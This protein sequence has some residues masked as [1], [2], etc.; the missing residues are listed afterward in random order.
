MLH[1][2][3]NPSADMWPPRRLHNVLL[4]MFDDLR[5]QLRSSRRVQGDE[6]TSFMRT[7]HLDALAS[8]SLSLSRAHVQVALCGPS[9]SSILVG[10]MPETVC[11]FPL[12]GSGVA[13]NWRVGGAAGGAGCEECRSLPE[14][15]RESGYT[16][17]GWGKVF[18]QSHVHG[19]DEADNPRSWD[20]WHNFGHPS[21]RS[22][23]FASGYFHNLH[24]TSMAVPAEVAKKK[25]LP[26]ELTVEGALPD[27]AR[28]ERA[29]QAPGGKPW[30]FAHGL[31]K[32]HEPFVAPARF[33]D[34]YPADSLPL[35]PSRECPPADSVPKHA[36][37]ASWPTEKRDV[38]DWKQCSIAGNG[39]PSDGKVDACN[40]AHC[41]PGTSSEVWMRQA[42]FA[43]VSHVD[44]L[45]GRLLDHV[46]GLGAWNHTVVVAFGDHGLKLGDHGLWGK[47]DNFHIDTHIPLLLRVPGLTA[48]SVESDA[49]VEA[50]DIFP[51]VVEAAGLPPVP[52]ISSTLE[53][54]PPDTG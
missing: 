9:R 27:L 12:D 32:P 51:S 16:A 49:M 52:R 29:R 19:S 48:P 38:K 53:S 42:Y 44:E 39:H 37:T 18:H 26:D 41:I 40:L 23:L 7:P 1:A 31:I 17:E 5:V 15:F 33:F 3:S 47:W 2:A 6:S 14:H 21:Y 35:S 11:S 4:L 24:L 28:L 36:F 43:C 50:V 25:P 22:L 13:P 54:M 20:Q 8:V 34:L 10:R 45:A 46:K 30:F